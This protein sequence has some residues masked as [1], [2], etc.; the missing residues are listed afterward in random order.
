MKGLNS[1]IKKTEI[2]LNEI[3]RRRKKSCQIR[4]IEDQSVHAT[5]HSEERIKLSDK[6]KQKL[7]SMRLSTAGITSEAIRS[8]Q[9]PHSIRSADDKCDLHTHPRNKN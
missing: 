5:I 6:K 3:I 9:I 8:N 1:A 2:N 7:I 4:Q